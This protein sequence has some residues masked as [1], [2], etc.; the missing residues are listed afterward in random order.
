[1]PRKP[2]LIRM[3]EDRARGHHT[4]LSY[5][6]NNLQCLDPIHMI[7]YTI[8]SRASYFQRVGRAIGTVRNQEKV[9]ILKS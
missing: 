1:M 7:Q 4:T 2:G 9:L 6:F 3:L 8:V 5:R